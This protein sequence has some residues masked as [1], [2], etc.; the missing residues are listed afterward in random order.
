M[1]TAT[2]LAPEVDSLHSGT[3]LF[4][5]ASIHSTESLGEIKRK[6]Q[7]ETP[8]SPLSLRWYG[9]PPPRHGVTPV[10]VTGVFDILHP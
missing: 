2:L 7:L 6:L 1:N 9:G 3:E 10:D 4:G 5:T 8:R